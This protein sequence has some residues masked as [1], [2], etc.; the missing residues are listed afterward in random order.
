MNI[1]AKHLT[2]FAS[3]AAT[4][5]LALAPASASAATRGAACLRTPGETIAQSRVYRIYK[6][7]KVISRSAEVFDVRVYSCRLD[8][9]KLRRF[10]YSRW[11]NDLDATVYVNYA[12]IAGRYALVK[13]DTATGVSD[14]QWLL[15][16]D[17]R[18]GKRQMIDPGDDQ[19]V[20][21]NIITSTGGVL[22]VH[23]PGIA[24]QT[25]H[26]FDATGDHTIAT[27]DFSEP[28]AGG[29]TAYWMQGGVAHSYTFV[30]AAAK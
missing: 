15:A 22:W 5:A 11:K 29:S 8:S 7:T 26:A 21:V 25:L 30:G 17:L 16:L 24:G 2:V 28:A 10:R 12:T 9:V 13:L 6:T 3:V 18:T 23:E 1:R 20:G 27:G 4:L 14:T 19:G